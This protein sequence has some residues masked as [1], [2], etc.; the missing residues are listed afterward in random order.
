MNRFFTISLILLTTTVGHVHANENIY[1]F[2]GH[3]Y[4][5]ISEP[6]SWNEALKFA[7][8][9]GGY[10]V[11]IDSF[12]ENIFIKNLLS[13][14]T[15]TASDGGDAKYAWLGGSL[16]NHT[17]LWKWNSGRTISL[18]NKSVRPFWGDGPGFSQ[19]QS[20]P[21][22]LV[23]DQDCLSIAGERWPVNS[24]DNTYL[25]EKGQ[26]NDLLCDNL[27]SFIIEYETEAVLTDNTFLELPVVMIDNQT[28]Q[29]SLQYHQCEFDQ[30]Q[31]CFMILSTSK[32]H[33]PSHKNIPKLKN[34]ELIIPRV[35]IKNSHTNNNDRYVELVL[36]FNQ[37]TFT[38]EKIS[39]SHI[40]SLNTYPGQ[41]NSFLADESSHSGDWITSTPESVGMTQEGIDM[42]MEYAFNDDQHTRSVLII[43]NGSIVTEKYSDGNNK[44]TISTSWSTAKS[45]VSALIGIAIDKNQIQSVD[46]PAS[47][48]ITEWKNTDKSFLSIKDFLQMSSTLLEIGNDG[49]LMYVGL[50][51]FDGSYT[52][53]DN[54][55]FSINRTFNPLRKNSSYKWNYQNADTQI[56][57][58]IIERASNESIYS[59]AQKNLFSKI[60]IKAD[61]WKDGFNNYMAY[62][63]LDMT[64]R[65]FA[66][67][68]L[69]FARDGRWFDGDI[70]NS[71]QQIVS[72]EYVIES[73]SPSVLI[74][75]SFYLKY[76]Y[77]WWVDTSG[78]WFVALGHGSNNIY[79]HPGLDLVVVRNSET[80]FNNDG[81]KERTTNYKISKL[82]KEWDH[83]K[84]FIPIIESAETFNQ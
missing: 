23:N 78:D 7:S 71:E 80:E 3:L 30:S 72:K 65:D 41:I 8:N 84:F 33:L 11:E 32:S 81:P 56:L 43:K 59:Y 51:T 74:S 31:D 6:I 4:E 61:W 62:C 34:E 83:R 76:G 2:E 55:E 10:L 66:K 15:T 54:L 1:S 48:F 63:C 49:R 52:L 69:L 28:Y 37:E 36:K 70:T 58:E 39:S 73:T 46:I 26:W 13:D 14:I 21:D 29:F 82:P 25:G 47:D 19:E 53:L 68:G 60:N 57:G 20:E 35:Q 16:D 9:K 38:F 79:V 44:D 45:F 27:L 42:A 64:S 22:Q 40:P 18:N 12:Q 17:E 24:K 77:Q 50:E 75:Q 5:Y 67:F